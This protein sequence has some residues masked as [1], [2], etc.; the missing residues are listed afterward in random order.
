MSLID[1]IA[2]WL[3]RFQPGAEETTAQNVLPSSLMPAAYNFLEA[4]RERLETIKFVRQMYK[5]DPRI[6]RIIRTLAHDMV[7]GGFTIQVKNHAPAQHVADDL[8]KRLNLEARLPEWVKLTL[9]D[10]DSFLE[11]AVDGDRQISTVTRKPTLGMRRN[12]DMFDQFTDPTKAFWWAGEMYW[13]M[14]AP[15]DAVWFAQWQIVHARWDHDEDNRYGVPLFGSATSAYKRTNEGETD[16]AI[17]RKTRAG[18]KY[19]HVVEGADGPG[20][21]SY[22]ELNQAAL[23]NPFAASA[24]FFTNKPGSITAI[25][26]DDKLSNIE[27]V[28][29]HVRTLFAATPLPMSLISYGQDLNRDVLEKQELQYRRELD[30]LTKWVEDEIVLPLLNLQWL[31]AGILPEGLDYAI[32][33][34]NKDPISATDIRDIAD[35]ALRLRAIGFDDQTILSILQQFMTGIDLTLTDLQLS[36]TERVALDA[37]LAAAGPA[38]G[39]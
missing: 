7:H 16:M 12:S 39:M 25:Q 1:T 5:V 35:A 11:P 36:D 8:I 26:G 14:E 29:H 27:D 10:G 30:P 31:L 28:M 4:E 23:D 24:D 13:G 17:R 38:Q 34:A 6:R 18:M 21:E 15:K 9:R 3:K 2:K 22:K 32:K 19:L 20:L 37:E 33:W